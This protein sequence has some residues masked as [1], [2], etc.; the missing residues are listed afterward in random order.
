VAHRLSSGHAARRYAAIEINV[1]TAA[2]TVK[3]TPSL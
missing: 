3:I 2:T 1:A